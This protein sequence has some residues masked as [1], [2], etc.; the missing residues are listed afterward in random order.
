MRSHER[1]NMEKPKILYREQILQLCRNAQ[2]LGKRS[3]GFHPLRFGSLKNAITPEQVIRHHRK[4]R[5]SFG[6]T[7]TFPTIILLVLC[8][9]FHKKRN[10]TE[11]ILPYSL[12][13]FPGVVKP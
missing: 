8:I 9:S 13:R 3:R 12:L 7:G 6:G 1:Q 2:L 4:R 10:S 11:P 5:G